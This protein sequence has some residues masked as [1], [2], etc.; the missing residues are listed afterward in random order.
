M[1]LVTNEQYE[2]GLAEF[3]GILL[4]DGSICIKNVN[5]KCHNRLKITLDSNSD[6]EYINYVSNLIEFLFNVKPHIKKRNNEN[7]VDIFVFNKE[8]ISFL[9]NE[10]GL[11]LSPKWNKAIVPNTFMRDNL[12][13][14]V[15]RGYFDT[16]GALVTTN[17]NGTI[18]PRLEMKVC[19]SPMQSQF[20]RILQKYNFKFGAYQIGKGKVRIQ[21]N[22]KRQLES[23]INLVGF[24]NQ[25]NSDKIKRFL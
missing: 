13:L 9:V 23:W 22:G 20:I 3:I 10:V 4:G 1:N 14:L 12:D 21:L 2:L 5:S 25:K 11:Q 8:L 15:I 18:Y 16:D 17:N 24:S 6:K 19:P 7:A